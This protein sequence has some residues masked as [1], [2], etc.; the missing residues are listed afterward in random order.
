[1]QCNASGVCWHGGGRGRALARLA[2]GRAV[3][4]VGHGRGAP[5]AFRS[6]EHQIG[7]ALAVRGRR[8][9]FGR[10]NSLFCFSVAQDG[11]LPA[12]TS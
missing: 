2:G 8:R 3:R 12:A 7:V 11:S 9:R 4:A 1:M 10:V 6:I 5:R